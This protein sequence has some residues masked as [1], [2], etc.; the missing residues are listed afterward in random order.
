MLT[1]TGQVWWETSDKLMWTEVVNFPGQPG[2]PASKKR[3]A[4]NNRETAAL[5]QLDP[6]GRIKESS[7]KFQIA[8]AGEVGRNLTT[9]HI[10]SCGIALS[11]YWPFEIPNVTLLAD[12][13]NSNDTRAAELPVKPR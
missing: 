6:L 2:D 10:Y 3:N 7:V 11:S 12:G 9:P 1:D 13:F 4:G 8:G 5:S